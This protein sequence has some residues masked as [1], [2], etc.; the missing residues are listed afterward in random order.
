MHP[1]PMIDEDF[2]TWENRAA[3][4]VYLWKFNELGQLVHQGVPGGGKVQITPK[5]RRINQEKVA[6][7][8]LDVFQNGMLAPLRLVDSDE[9]TKTL[10]A[11][12]NAMSETAM[13]ALFRSQ[14]AT[15]TKKI[16]EISNPITLSRLIEVASEVDATI[17]QER[18]IRD[19]LAEVTP[20]VDGSQRVGSQHYAAA[21]DA[22][23]RGVTP[24]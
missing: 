18:I 11:N 9:D 6:S 24:R 23:M 7:A 2:E 12:S 5:E 13:K 8:D 1:Q 20:T 14:V 19:R 15:F 16:N 21:G 10:Q 17:R 22:P 4:L 3:G